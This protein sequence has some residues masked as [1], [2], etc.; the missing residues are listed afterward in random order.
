MRDC[1]RILHAIAG[2]EHLRSTCLERPDY[3]AALSGD[4]RGLRLG[5]PQDGSKASNPA[6]A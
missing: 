1:A 4:I 2:P 3:E 6:S 5:V